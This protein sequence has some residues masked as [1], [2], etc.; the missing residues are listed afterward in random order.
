M[1]WNCLAITATRHCLYLCAMFVAHYTP[2]II[3]IPCIKDNII[4]K[5]PTKYTYSWHIFK[6]YRLKIYTVP[7]VSACTSHLQGDSQTKE[8]W[9]LMC[10]RYKFNTMWKIPPVIS[11]N[12]HSSCKK[13]LEINGIIYSNWYCE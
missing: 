11:T 4:H 2:N 13:F 1:S 12:L 10:K 3:H 9:L 5:T 8:F 7:H 6:L